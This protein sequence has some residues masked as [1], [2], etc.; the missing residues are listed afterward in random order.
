MAI[1]IRALL[2]WVPYNHNM[3]P[4]YDILDSITNPI[5]EATYKLTDGRANLNGVDFSPMLAYFGLHLLKIFLIR[6]F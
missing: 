3:K 4:V 2:S 6:L 1:V 5:M